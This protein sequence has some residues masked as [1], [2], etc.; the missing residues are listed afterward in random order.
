[1]ITGYRY[2]KSSTARLAT[3]AELI[4]K[5]FNWAIKHRDGTIAQGHRGEEEQNE[6]FEKRL[7]QLK[8]PASS[9]NSLPA[10]AVDAVPYIDGK[11]IFGNAKDEKTRQKELLDMAH[12]AGFIVGASY[13]MRDVGIIDYVLKWGGDWNSNGSVQ[14]HDFLDFPHFEI[15]RG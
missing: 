3:T 8:F 9:H 15:V 2:G 14:D 4:Q 6:Y 10:N 7:T 11:A 5:V 13:H 12:Y 1:M